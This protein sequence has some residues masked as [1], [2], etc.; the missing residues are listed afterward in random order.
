M[1]DVSK[2]SITFK[3]KNSTVQA[4]NSLSY[5]L[6]KGDTLGIVG[7]SGSGK[8]VSAL[9]LL[10]LLPPTAII[11]G[12]INFCNQS[13]LT[14]NQNELRIIRGKQI[15][16]V[17][18]NPLAALNPVFSIANQMIETICLHHG[19]SKADARKT[20]IELL[21]RV[22]IPQA[23]QRIDDYPHQFS[24][25]MCQR[26]MI[27]ITLSMEPDLVIA[28]EPTA[29]LDVTVQ[30][31]IMTLLNELQ[32]ELGMSMLLISHDLGLIAQNCDY[33][34]IMYLGRI[35]EEGSPI[36]IFK[37]PKH[38]YTQALIKCKPSVHTEE[39]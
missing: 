4:V 23:A 3:L 24:I 25:G 16:F 19:V 36:Q 6:T 5:Q 29:S 14:L 35:V 22:K 34:Y 1:L 17:F 28:D 33:I 21:D 39:S 13:L 11:T 15:G 8:S 27:A 37:D 12:E 2:L 18:Q 20:A 10:G 26:I 32:S 9:A 30:N 38:P 31:Q 7:E